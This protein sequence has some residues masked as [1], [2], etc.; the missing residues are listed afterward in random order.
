MILGAG[1]AAADVRTVA[2]KVAELARA[3]GS[4]L[5]MG[6]LRSVRGMGAAKAAQI[7]AAI[8]FARRVGTSGRARIS[9]ARDILPLV[10][11][12]AMKKQEYFVCISLNGAN[13]VIEKRTVTVG[14]L[15]QTSIHPR[16]VFADVITDRAAAVVLVHNPPS[17]HVEPLE[18]DR[19][20]PR[21]L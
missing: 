19:R 6:H 13:E 17:G 20:I 8:E 9:T 15:D 5:S 18:A 1:T 10:A 2:R 7:L 12:I 16:E 11:D 3:H 14:L 21:M 4:D